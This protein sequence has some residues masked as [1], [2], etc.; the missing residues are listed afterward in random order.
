MDN[1]QMIDS[2]SVFFESIDERNWI[3]MRQTLAD[4][5]ILDSSPVG[6]PRR[7]LS[8]DD[9]VAL[10]RSVGGGFQNTCHHFGNFR[11]QQGGTHGEIDCDLMA[12]HYLPISSGADTFVLFRKMKAGLSLREDGQWLITYMQTISE[13]QAGNPE[14]LALAQKNGQEHPPAVP[15]ADLAVASTEEGPLGAEEVLPVTNEAVLDNFFTFLENKDEPGFQ[16]LWSEDGSWSM[17]FYA[18]GG[19]QDL[20]GK[21]S[22]IEYFRRTSN[23]FPGSKFDRKYRHTDDPDIIIVPYDRK[24]LSAEGAEQTIV[25][26]AIFSFKKGLIR[27]V[28]DYSYPD[29]RSNKR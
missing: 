20:S 26:A 10:S 21:S 29:E 23:G 25:C 28:E 24:Y 11:Q 5:V 17:P 2:L 9:L 14:L 8:G 15:G 19:D 16:S 4:T 1:R 18:R 7:E 6:R 27:G 12:L 22:V 3:K 13:Q